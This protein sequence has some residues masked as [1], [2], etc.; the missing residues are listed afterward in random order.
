MNS[1]YDTIPQVLREAEGYGPSHHAVYAALRDHCDR[2][3]IC[4]PSQRRIGEEAGGLSRTR[5]CDLIGDLIDLGVVERVAHPPERAHWR[6]LC[7]RLPAVA[8]QPHKVID[9]DGEP[10]VRTA[11]PPVRGDRIG[12]TSECRRADTTCR[13]ADTNSNNPNLDTQPTTAHTHWQ[14]TPF[15]GGILP[16]DWRP[17]PQTVKDARRLFPY[18]DPDALALKLIAWSQDHG[19]VY[20]DPDSALLHWAK[21]E[22]SP[23]NPG[24]GRMPWEAPPQGRAAPSQAARQQEDLAA[25]NDAAAQSALERILARR[26]SPPA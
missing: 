4:Y 17:K 3:G 16:D 11:D 20:D 18:V 14:S 19:K 23:Q 21:R 12:V 1:P 9:D 13:Q 2:H 7:Y 8:E 6:T 5:A 24:R 25:R 26:A 15:D 22:W 10:P